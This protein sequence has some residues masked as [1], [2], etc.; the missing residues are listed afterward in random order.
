MPFANSPPPP[1]PDMPLDWL[2]EARDVMGGLGWRAEH[3]E[4]GR[5]VTAAG[6]PM[7]IVK[8]TPSDGRE[9]VALVVGLQPG[10]FDL[11][12]TEHTAK[13]AREGTLSDAPGVTIEH[14]DIAY[15]LRQFWTGERVEL[16]AVAA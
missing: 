7:Q 1:P 10:R 2:H 8:Q 12:M 14:N 4:L 3:G 13:V 11:L 6:E 16:R 5:W 9:R 15:T